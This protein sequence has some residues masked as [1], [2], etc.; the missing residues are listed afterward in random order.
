ML[1]RINKFGKGPG[2]FTVVR[3]MSIVNDSLYLYDDSQ[4]KILVYDHNNNFVREVSVPEASG[5]DMVVNNR[6]HIFLSTPNRKSP[7]TK[8]STVGQKITAFGRNTVSK[9]SRRYL[10]NS[11]FLFI[12]NDKM[13][14]VGRSENP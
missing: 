12:H 9:D 7:I 8:F 14:A 4:A 1:G 3:D 13:I 6:S 5:F 10:R 11:R 2:E